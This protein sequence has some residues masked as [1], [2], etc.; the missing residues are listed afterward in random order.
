M[1]AP[2]APGQRENKNEPRSIQLCGSES[3]ERQPSNGGY[4]YDE[5]EWNIHS[6]SFPDLLYRVNTR[7]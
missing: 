7:A 1:P 3:D 2:R 6:R 4:E 5:C